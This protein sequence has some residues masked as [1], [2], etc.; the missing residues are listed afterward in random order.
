MAYNR[1]FR[2]SGRSKEIGCSCGGTAKL[3]SRKNY[4]Y[5][6]KSDSVTSWFYKCKSCGALTFN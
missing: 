3:S 2:G 6:K 5:G 1:R 4:P